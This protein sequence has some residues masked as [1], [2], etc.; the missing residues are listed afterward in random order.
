M[1]LLSWCFFFI[2]VPIISVTSPTTDQ[3][4]VQGG[5]LNIS[6]SSQNAPDGSAVV[7]SLV[8]TVTGTNLGIVARN[9]T[10]TGNTSW[11]LPA[12]GARALCADCGGIQ[13]MVPVGPYKII[14]KM[15]TPSDAWFGDTP[16]PENPVQQ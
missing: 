14:A 15:Y 3:T 1:V 7:L 5:T 6:W 4:V 8:N 2:V 9:Q 13:E 16:Q 11:N 12:V 10:T